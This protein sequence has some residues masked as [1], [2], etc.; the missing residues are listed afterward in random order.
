MDWVGES[1]KIITEFLPR[2]LR[3]EPAKDSISN[4]LYSYLTN[5]HER[6]VINKPFPNTEE[7]R[8]VQGAPTPVTKHKREIKD[9]DL[10]YIQEN[11]KKSVSEINIEVF[12]VV[13]VKV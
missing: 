6:R 10:Y 9:E 5:L 4:V 1:P 11:L 2:V 3:G 7:Y 8:S 12:G 13:S